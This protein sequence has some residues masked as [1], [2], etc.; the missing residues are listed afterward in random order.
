MQ[1]GPEY[2][3]YRVLERL[4]GN[5]GAAAFLRDCC[6]RFL[7]LPRVRRIVEGNVRRIWVHSRGR[8]ATEKEIAD[9]LSEM[10]RI[11]AAERLTAIELQRDPALCAVP[12]E[13]E[14]LPRLEALRSEGHG[15]VLA[16]P[17]FGDVKMLILGLARQGLP[18]H[19]MVNHAGPWL[20]TIEAVQPNLRF[21]D[22]ST[23]AQYYLD[24]LRR[25]EVVL[26]YT[27]MDFFPGGRTA[28]FFG[29]PCH[30]PHGPARLALASGAPLLPAYSVFKDGRHRLMCAEPLPA[31]GSSQEELEK[32]LLLS[33]EHFIS[34]HPPHWLIFHDP[35]D[36][37]ARVRAVRHQLRHIRF[38]FFM[39]RLWG[40]LTNAST[41][42]KDTAWR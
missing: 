31:I 32:G 29:A 25:N 22:F 5:E 23:G 14:L 21:T 13:L 33:M 37:E 26:L 15:V 3:F 36:L 35:W 39:D 24:A 6:V 30:P 42:A 11:L 4:L 19:V 38:S 20:R 10:A 18:L 34:R 28:V 41:P 40:R 2:Y 16:T 9:S 27:D 8:E 17:H 12:V 1:K 7:A